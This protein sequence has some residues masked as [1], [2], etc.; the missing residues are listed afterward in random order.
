MK[1]LEE[2][3]II[4]RDHRQSEQA[5]AA[6]LQQLLDEAAADGDARFTPEEEQLRKAVHDL[7]D[8]L[9]TQLVEAEK[10]LQ[11]LE[12]D[13]Q[14]LAKMLAASPAA[15]ARSPTAVAA[16]QRALSSS[17]SETEGITTDSPDSYLDGIA[18]GLDDDAEVELRDG[19]KIRFRDINVHDPLVVKELLP[20]L[21]PG[22]QAEAV[23]AMLW[24]TLDMGIDS[25][26]DQLTRA[27]L[28][29]QDMMNQLND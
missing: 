28:D 1:T 24:Q 9:G 10:R 5:H 19:S 12:V 17:M 21:K 26:K 25:L 23:Q 14:R 29:L 8:K 27:N 2:S 18:H 11:Q 7:R 15:S 16:A 6:A 20:Q 13:K 4:E 3:L 22:P